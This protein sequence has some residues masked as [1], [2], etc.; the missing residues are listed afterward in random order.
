[1][2]QVI[3]RVIRLNRNDGIGLD[4]LSHR[5]GPHE[6]M[7]MPWS[8]ERFWREWH[9]VFRTRKILVSRAY[10][11][12]LSSWLPWPK[13]GLAHDI[14]A[15]SSNALMIAGSFQGLLGF[16]SSELNQAD[17]QP[18]A[19]M[20]VRKNDPCPASTSAPFQWQSSK[21]C[22]RLPHSRQ[23]CSR[24]QKFSPELFSARAHALQ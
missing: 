21:Q 9:G 23:I 18:V 17:A 6:N 20:P 12:G 7:S 15:Q 8:Y 3:G 2:P 1:M 22:H 24:L 10:A 13:A 16:V 14:Q 4:S 19:L 11:H 5:G